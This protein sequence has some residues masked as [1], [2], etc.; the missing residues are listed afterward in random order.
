MQ[1]EISNLVVQGVHDGYETQRHLR[2]FVAEKFP[3]ASVDKD[4]KRLHPSIDQIRSSMYVAQTRNM[5]SKNDQENLLLKVLKIAL[6][7]ILIHR[8]FL[9]LK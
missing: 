6:N 3:A 7:S 1:R 4:N 5:L 2:R 9:G 8:F